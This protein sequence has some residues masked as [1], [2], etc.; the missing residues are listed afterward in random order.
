M[1]KLTIAG[2]PPA[3]VGRHE[4]PGTARTLG[5]YIHYDGQPVNP[6]KCATPVWL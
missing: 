6:A 5:I 4:A 3:I 1:G 2:A